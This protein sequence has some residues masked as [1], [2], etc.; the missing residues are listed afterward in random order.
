[1]K[2]SYRFSK[3]KQVTSLLATLLCWG[4]FLPDQAPWVARAQEKASTGQNLPPNPVEQAERD[5]TALRL[6]LR[7]LTKLALQ[8][9]LDIA[10]SDT[11]EELYQQRLIQ[12]YGPYDPALV[13]GLGV[14]SAKSPNTNLTN[15]STQGNFNK[16]D[17]ANWNFQFSQNIPTG[18][19]IVAKYN[20]YRF[21]TNQQFALFTPQYSSSL[22]IQFT[23]PLRRNLRIDQNRGAIKLANLDKKLNDS[24]F[25]QTVTTTIASIQGLYWDLVASIRDYDIKKE[26]VDLAR[27]SLDNNTREVDIGVLAP[28]SITEAQAEMANREVDLITSRES[29][30]VAENNLRAAVAPDRNAEI[31][32]KFIVPTD[33]PDF[34][35]YKP[36]LDKAIETAIQNRPELQQY[37]LQLEQNDINY[38]VDRDLKKWQVDLVG[39]FGTTGVGGPQAINPL[40]GEPLIDPTLIGGI[41]TA[42]KLIF[43]GGFTNWSAGFNVQIPLRNR[44]VDSQLGQL[45][46]Q[47]QQ[48]LMNRRSMEQ[49]ISV[50]V[51][52][53][54]EDLTANKQRVETAKVALRLANEQLVGETK[55]FQAGMS[56]NFLVLQRQQQLSAAKGTELQALIAHKKSII[57]LQQTMYTLLESNDFEVAKTESHAGRT[58]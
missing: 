26:A 24:Q 27:I 17:Y 9:N 11:N 42:N 49:K 39:I 53:A 43:S 28:I 40:T 33:V 7:D 48:L 31:W 35:E 45:K 55:R 18:G 6:S 4:L 52:N 51:R 57:A 14:Q 54:I 30:I 19:G 56:Q 12:T 37:G 22:S 41:G 20:S 58:Q 44:T 38:R 1:M 46:V 3:R 29:I 36:N 2:N 5:G 15:Q 34:Q 13:I 50:Q 21:D 8:N 23:Q 10:I 47:R 32:H 25:R 16:T